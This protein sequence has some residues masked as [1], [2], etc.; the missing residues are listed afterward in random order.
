MDLTF[1]QIFWFHFHIQAI[2]TA[3]MGKAINFLQALV[4]PRYWEAL[5]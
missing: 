4:A 1:R 2:C 3:V 5:Q